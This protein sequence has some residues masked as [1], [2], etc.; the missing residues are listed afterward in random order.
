MT[1]HQPFQ[2]AGFHSC[3]KEVGL[4]VLN[5]ET[6]LNPSENPWDWLG[7][8]IYFWE[9]NPGRAL[10]YA[11][12]SAEGKQKNK[13][14]IATPFVLGG[15]IELGKCLNLLESESLAVVKQAYDRLVKTYA[16]TSREMP[17]NKGA[18][19]ELDCAV[20]RSVHEVARVKGV[21][22]YDT[23]RSAFQEGHALYEGSNFTDRLHVEL[24]VINKEMIK[25]YFLP[26]PIDRFN[27]N[28]KKAA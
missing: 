6:D 4:K 10:L 14:R 19:R 16:Q 1:Y 8:G 2:I 22:P 3:D 17:V 26:R 28:L 20:I 5:G 21:S 7:H 24:C 23:V 27:P 9:Q 13:T 18:R 11:N 12:E 25:G 15:I